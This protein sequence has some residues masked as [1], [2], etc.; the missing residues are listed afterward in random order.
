M[1]HPVA[2]KL[3][4]WPWVFISSCCCWCSKKPGTNTL[5]MPAVNLLR[6]FQFWWESDVNIFQSSLAMRHVHAGRNM[7]SRS[8]PTGSSNWVLQRKCKFFKYAYFNFRSKIQLGHRVCAIRRFRTPKSLKKIF[9]ATW[10]TI[11]A[12][13]L[14]LNSQDDAQITETS[15]PWRCASDNEVEEE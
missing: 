1:D 5:D 13:L 3:C 14:R 6:Q 8:T 12:L 7:R 10:I 15:P 2:L 9:S 11:R 4:S